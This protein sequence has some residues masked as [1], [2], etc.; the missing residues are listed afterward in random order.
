MSESETA[1]ELQ[2]RQGSPLL[3]VL[4]VVFC[5]FIG[6]LVFTYVVTKRTHPVYVDERGNPVNADSS[7]GHGD[8]GSSKK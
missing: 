4:G 1:N 6:I 3:Y 8:T 5:L 2:R 7:H